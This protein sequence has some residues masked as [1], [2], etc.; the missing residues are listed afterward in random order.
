[1]LVPLISFIDLISTLSLQLSPVSS[2]LADGDD[3]LLGV[4][5]SGDV[6]HVHAVSAHNGEVHLSIPPDVFVGG[7]NPPN[8]SA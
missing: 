7:F 1:M 2:H 5:V 6:K 4:F 3:S 8:W